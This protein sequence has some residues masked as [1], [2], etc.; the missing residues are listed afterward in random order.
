MLKN[1]CQ[2]ELCRSVWEG[3]HRYMKNVELCADDEEWVEVEEDYPLT[4]TGIAILDSLEKLY[5][6]N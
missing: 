3:G 2:C 1:N 4:P 6:N 5:E